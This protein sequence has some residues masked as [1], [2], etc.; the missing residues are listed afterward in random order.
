MSDSIR[1]KTKAL[2]K[3][4]YALA[5]FGEAAANL[6]IPQ[7]GIIRTVTKHLRPRNQSLSE[8]KN[9]VEKLLHAQ[10]RRFFVV[11]DDIDRLTSDE[12]RQLFRVIKA[13]VTLRRIT[14]I[15]AFDKEIVA[16]ALSAFHETNWN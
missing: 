4:R 13:V 1:P 11:V 8:L 16:S 10:K 2:R 9:R 12:I 7:Q 6:P 14:Y 15:L 5:D 3:I